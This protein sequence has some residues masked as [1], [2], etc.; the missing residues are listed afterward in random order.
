MIN[1]NKNSKV[2]VFG[3]A[4]IETGGIE[5]LYALYSAYKDLGVDAKMV[6]IHPD[7]HPQKVGDWKKI[8]ATK[9]HREHIYVPKAYEK[10]ITLDNVVGE[11]EDDENNL[12]IL[13][14]I[15]PD[16]LDEYKHI[17]KS[18]W[19][20]SVANAV[21]DDQKA[22][23]TKL[24]NPEYLNVHH[25]YQ[26]H[27]AYWFLLTNGAQYVYPLFDYINRDYITDITYEN[28]DNV[29]LYNPKKGIELTQQLINENPDIE[30]IPLINMDR[31]QLRELMLK[32]KIY[33]DFGHHP[34]K[35]KFPREA[36]SC[37]CVLITSFEGSARFF[38]DVTIDSKYKFENIEG[39]SDLIKNIFNN[40]ESHFN[41][42]NLYRKIINNEVETFINQVKHSCT[43]I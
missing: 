36:A 39:V 35:D 1:L 5:C 11:I 19:W 10:Y 15:W 41:N 32:S 9:E 13:P 24:S 37:G 12:I 16:I 25:F 40:F 33:I 7:V 23:Y 3:P 14:E 2:Y 28:R 22:F 20:L 43:I 34:G 17:Q 42:F 8:I 21:G 4:N 30:F 6:L 31:H 26:S 38:Q 29:V 18:I 27:Y